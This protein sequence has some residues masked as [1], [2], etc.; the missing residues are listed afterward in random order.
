M[1]RMFVLL[2]VAAFLGLGCATTP[3]ARAIQ[4]T[5]VGGGLVAVGST[6]LAGVALT[7]AFLVTTLPSATA[8]DYLA[9]L[10][11]GMIVPAAIL[12]GG[13]VTIYTFSDSLDGVAAEAPTSSTTIPARRSEHP[14]V[15]DLRTSMTC[16]NLALARET[17]TEV[18]VQGCNRAWTCVL[19]G[20]AWGCTET[21]PPKKV[22]PRLTNDDFN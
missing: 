1:V 11:L 16:P 14:V 15:T 4:G 19:E 12:A 7:S 9:P 5:A 2:V 18:D 22:E 10:A 13:A 6:S 21:T 17:P 8:A 20:D 3:H